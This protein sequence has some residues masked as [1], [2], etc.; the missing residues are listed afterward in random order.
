M[1]N[2]GHPTQPASNSIKSNG[3][4]SAP[5]KPGGNAGGNHPQQ[6]SSNNI[7]GNGGSS[8]PKK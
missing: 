2:S 5:S 8:S 1:A 7:R 3:G 6:P 4:S